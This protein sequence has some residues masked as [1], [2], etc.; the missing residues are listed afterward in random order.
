VQNFMPR[1]RIKDGAVR[2]FDAFTPRVRVSGPIRAGRLW[3]SESAN[4]RFVRTRVDELQPLDRSEQQ[5]TA[6][7]FL[8][9]VDYARSSAHH[10]TKTLMWF[11]SNVDNAG[12]DTWHPLETTPDLAQRAGVRRS[13][14]V[15]C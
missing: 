6:F 9:Q 15:S 13:R 4:Y 12:I 2:G 7:D 5:V 10:V 14:I 11:P 8:S 3:F 1:L